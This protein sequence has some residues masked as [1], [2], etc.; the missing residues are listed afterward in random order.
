MNA[1]TAAGS[2]AAAEASGPGIDRRWAAALAAVTLLAGAL[3]LIALGRVPVNP[4]YDAAVRS[5]SRSLHNFFYGAF[6]PGA[7]ASIDKPPID[8]W[9]QVVSVK[10]LGFSSTTL[11]LPEALSATAA[12]PLLY[13]LVRRLA[14]RTAALASAATLAVLPV[15]VVTA[16]SD[17]MDSAM[18]ALLVAVAWLALRAVERRRLRLAV[19]AAAVLGLAFNVKLFEALVP[20][21]A[22]LVFGLIALRVAPWAV[23][24]R[25]LV[26]STLAFAA[27]AL[28]WLAI[29]SLTPRHD[30]PY[31]IGSTNG[32]VWNAV[33]VFN[34]TQRITEPPKPPPVDA[35]PLPA[36]IVADS[37]V[38]HL[39]AAPA[40]RAAPAVSAPAGPVRLFERSRVDFGGLI[41]T[42]LLAALLFGALALASVR[43]R[44]PRAPI[45]AG[46]VAG[47]GVWLLTGYALFSFAG[48]VHPRYLEA[49]TPAVA[50]ALGVALAALA[51]GVRDARSALLLAAPLLAIAAWALVP[52]GGGR[53]LLTGVGAGIAI[54]LG[55]AAGLPV[56]LRDAR[57]LGGWPAWCP[58][59]LLAGSALAA[60]LA[61]PLA[62]DVRLIRDHSGVQAASPL[63]RPNVVAALSS[64]LRAH[65]GR[66][67]YEVAASAPTIVDQLVVRDARPV[68]L[69]TT[70]DARP[71]VTLAKLRRDATTAQ[72]SYVL[73]HGRC[74][75]RP[76]HLLPACSTAARW[77]AAHS[78]DVTAQLGLPG[79]RSGLLYRL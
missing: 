71:L 69:L 7:S 56:A 3:R 60:V 1:T 14:G 21:P 52:A 50:I 37:G 73:I 17:T 40:R 55:V 31:P 6:E 42:V 29:V 10:L 45:V 75:T 36:T 32:S 47:V 74:P 39:A 23:R 33:F 70:I 65:D 43:D 44:L 41:G 66:A 18:M 72:V 16:R 13:D 11:K 20:V 15:A 76:Y 38:P 35:N 62:R 19:L 61:F 79:Y 59:T 28:A 22:L 8:L 27:V 46:A 30:R 12:V 9:L 24:A 68:L 5:M 78:R 67:R 26:A 48:R 34:G 2:A 25:W 4:F 58:P 63:L 77:V 54:A 57:R 51:R 49:F 64:Y 53:L